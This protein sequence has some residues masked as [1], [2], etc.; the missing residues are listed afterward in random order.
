MFA[1]ELKKLLLPFFILIIVGVVLLTNRSFE[2]EIM[3]LALELL[4]WLNIGWFLAKSVNLWAIVVNNYFQIVTPK[5]LKD[6]TIFMIFV[7]TVVGI[8]AIVLKF[9]IGGIFITSGIASIFVG[10]LLKN[11]LTDIFSGIILNIELPYKIGDFIEIENGIKGKVVDINW[12]TTTIKPISTN[13][14]NIIPNKVMIAMVI[15]NYNRPNEY[16]RQYVELK[17]AFSVEP[18]HAISILTAAVQA[19]EEKF[20]NTKTDAVIMGIDDGGIR[21]RIRYWIPEF[22]LQH[23]MR[24]RVVTSVMKHLY[25]AGITPLYNPQDLFVATMPIKEEH[26]LQ[27]ILSRILLFEVFTDEELAKLTKHSNTII[28][29]ADEVIVSE[30]DTK[31]S[32]YVILEGLVKLEK[33]ENNQQELLKTLEA[34]DIFGE[35]SLLTNEKYF[36][37]ITTITKTVLCE[38]EEIDIRDI[39]QNR[40][41]IITDLS[42]TLAKHTLL[43]KDCYLKVAN[44]V[45]AKDI[46][47][48]TL[49]ERF[50]KDI[51][52]AFG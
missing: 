35:F 41:E 24:T 23:H 11:V 49:A 37:T 7:F 28:K 15:K 31:R 18:S 52:K 38:I 6:I 42:K 25:Q 3:H 2:S 50:L 8:L 10:L 12:R 36:V 16:Y 47:N 9:P 13:I 45:D 4:L 32:L 34:G 27:H 48:E 46:S 33:E 30:N 22:L 51:Q 5:L 29:K 40:P 21:Y 26:N 39:L 1:S 43:N 17:L 14:Y 20:K 19:V 44:D